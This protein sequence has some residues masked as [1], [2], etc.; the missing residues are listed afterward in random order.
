MSE[1]IHLIKS[2]VLVI[3][4]DENDGDPTQ[5]YLLALVRAILALEPGQWDHLRRVLDQSQ[6]LMDAGSP[7]VGPFF[8]VV[9]TAFTA[10]GEVRDE[11]AL[12]TSQIEG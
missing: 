3:P 2:G 11:H 4:L 6:S 8:P 10:F 5:A 12:I 7:L 9:R 1:A